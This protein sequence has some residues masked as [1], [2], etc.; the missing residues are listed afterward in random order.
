ML[1]SHKVI[2]LNIACAII[3]F[4]Y[5][6]LRCYYRF[7]T[8]DPIKN[9][10]IM[11]INGWS[12]SHFIFNFVQGYLFPNQWCVSFIMGVF[13][14]LLET[15]LYYIP[16]TKFLPCQLSDGER[17]VYPD[18]NDILFNALG[19]VVGILLRKRSL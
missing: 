4:V 18:S 19:L 8:N 7:R 11:G 16:P 17:W 6:Y 10:T 1:D 14:E 15:V 5:G 3:I 9:A 12:L 2:T 13:W